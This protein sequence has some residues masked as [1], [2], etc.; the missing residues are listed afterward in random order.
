M[1]P[2]TGTR[3]PGRPSDPLTLTADA[4]GDTLALGVKPSAP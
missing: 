2:L 1:D 3:V 4:L